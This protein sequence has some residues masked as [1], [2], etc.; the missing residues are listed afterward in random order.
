MRTTTEAS[1][2]SLRTPNSGAELL[3]RLEAGVRRLGRTNVECYG[4]IYVKTDGERLIAAF[5]IEEDSPLE[6]WFYFEYALRDGEL[7]L[8]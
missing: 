2:P 6:R 4:A 1:S 5:R 7:I 8:V 3:S